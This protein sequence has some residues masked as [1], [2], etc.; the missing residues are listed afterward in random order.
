MGLAIG[1][2]LLGAFAAVFGMIHGTL[3]PGDLHWIIQVLHV[4]IGIAAIGLG[5][6]ISAR[7]K[8]AAV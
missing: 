8:R 6:A 4:L 5:E 1:A 3:L 7:V 2:I